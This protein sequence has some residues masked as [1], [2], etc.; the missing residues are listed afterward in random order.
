MTLALGFR[1]AHPSK[2]TGVVHL[3]SVNPS[4]IFGLHSGSWTV[5][6]AMSKPVTTPPCAATS[7]LQFGGR[8]W[9]CMG[10]NIWVEIRRDNVAIIAAG[11]A[12]FTMLAIFPLITV[13]LS[14]FG[15]IADPHQLQ[16]QLEL[17]SS[18]MPPEAWAILDTQIM[19]V[20]GAPNGQLGLRIAIGLLIALWSA[21]SG[22]RAI[23]QAMNIA[24]DEVEARG[25]AK[26]YALAS[27]LTLSIMIFLWIALAVIIGVPAVLALLKLDGLVAIVTQYLPW[28]L[29][30]L[31]FAFAVAILYLFGPSRRP[32]KIKWVMPGVLFATLSWLSISAAFSRFVA[33]FGSYNKTYGS[34]SAVI[35]LLVWFWLTALVII[36]GAEINAEMERHTTVDT[37]RGPDREIGSR[38]AAVADFGHLG[39]GVI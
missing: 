30:V 34:I 36:V 14:I 7:P 12:F 19:A 4:Q 37:T 21:G 31:L 17:I 2:K 11:V 3:V 6:S 24:Y 25:P 18:L 28:I 9:I 27:T 16:T 1:R 35:I 5:Q 29:L 39:Q 15:Y 8:D 33:A 22:I 13:C 23:M 20:A 32:A 10:K 38:G 26:F